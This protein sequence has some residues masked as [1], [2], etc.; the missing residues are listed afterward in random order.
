MEYGSYVW[1]PQYVVLHKELESVQQ[2]T[3]I[4]ETGSMT[5]IL[6]QLKW[7]S[8]KKTLKDNISTHTIV[9]RTQR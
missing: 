9:Q 4:C 8:F 7:K 2:G 6:G 3:T 1:D 5:G